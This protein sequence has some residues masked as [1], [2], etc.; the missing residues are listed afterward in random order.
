MM[1][2]KT[3]CNTFLPIQRAGKS[4]PL[5]S[6]FFD[7]LESGLGNGLEIGEG[8]GV[9]RN[10]DYKTKE[11][12][13]FT[14]FRAVLLAFVVL[15]L[16]ACGDE[17]KSLS[18]EE[19]L[20]AKEFLLSFDERALPLVLEDTLL[21]KKSAD[22]LKIGQKL[23]NRFIPDTVFHAL[24]GKKTSPDVFPIGRIS[25]KNAETFI[26]IRA[27]TKAKRAAYLLA[28]NELDSFVVAMPLLEVPVKGINAQTGYQASIDRKK[29]ILKTK[30]RRQ[31]SGEILYTK[32]AFVYNN[33]G[34]FT[35]ILTES[36]DVEKIRSVVENP[37]DTFP[38]THPLAGDYVQNKNNYVSVRDGRNEKEI[39]FFI[40]FEKSGDCNG[41]IKGTA[42]F[43]SPNL[44]RYTQPGDPCVL[45]LSFKNGKVTLKEEKGCGAYRGI[46]C[47]FEGTYTRKKTKNKN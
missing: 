35:L 37:I 31:K 33:A 34:V 7:E 2:R 39:D 18:G 13:I 28:Y 14:R 23:V 43:I 8:I 1:K 45:D 30:L 38:A 44:A 16:G 5:V 22:S 46:K 10:S 36:N 19:E 32:Q 9:G 24:F 12:S 42:K 15:V 6:L 26:L 20:T 11:G 3:S 4:S 41:E 29:T 17:K 21:L 47:F 40:H 27:E 25:S